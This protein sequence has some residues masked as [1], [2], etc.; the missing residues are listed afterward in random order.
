MMQV[1]QVVH[2]RSQLSDVNAL[3]LCRMK[4]S[5]CVQAIRAATRV[6]LNAV[7]AALFQALPRNDK[8]KMF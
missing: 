1:Q 5:L 4:M 8:I 2:H 3:A 6:F 7:Q